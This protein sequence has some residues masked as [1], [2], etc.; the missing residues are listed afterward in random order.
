MFTYHPRSQPSPAQINSVFFSLKDE[1]FLYIPIPKII[2]LLSRKG[3]GK[4]RQNPLKYEKYM[5]TRHVGSLK[6]QEHENGCHGGLGNVFT[7]KSMNFWSILYCGIDG[8]VS[9]ILRYRSIKHFVCIFRSF[10]YLG[11]ATPHGAIQAKLLANT[12]PKKW[13]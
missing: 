9:K 4:I 7:L 8:I 3:T 12:L 6:L 1:C 10:K 13:W 5:K 2:D 11:T